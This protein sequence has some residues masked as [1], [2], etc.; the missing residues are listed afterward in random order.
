VKDAFLGALM[1]T[2]KDYFFCDKCKNKNFI[3]IYNFSTQFRRVNFSDDL[4]YD[5]VTEEIY[6]CA[7]C[8]KTFS[9]HQIETRLKEITDERLRSLGRAGK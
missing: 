1:D 5:E 2:I 8:Y 7:H 3:Q 4:I 6:E 9:K